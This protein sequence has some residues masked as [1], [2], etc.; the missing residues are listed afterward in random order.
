M[1]I[2]IAA[3]GTGGHVFPSLCVAEKLREL[4][5]HKVFFLGT[6]RGLEAG[7]V[8]S[9]GFPVLYVSAR[10]WN[11]RIGLQMFRMLGENFLGFCAM[12]WYFLWYRPQAFF[13]MGSYLS[14]LGGLWAK[15]LRVP[16][17]LHEQNVYPGLAN[18]VVARWARKVFLS[19]EET[20]EYLRTRGRVEVTG[21]PLR[22]EVVAWEGKKEEACALL[23]L[24]K[25]RKT[26]LVAGGSRGSSFLNRVFLEALDFLPK[27]MIQVVH[28]TGVEDFAPIAEYAE[29]QPFPYRVF[30]FLDAMGMAYAAA[31]V[32][33]C[34]AGANTVTELFFFGIPSILVPYR[35]ATENHQWYNAQWLVKQGLAVVFSEEELRGPLLARELLRLLNRPSGFPESESRR[36]QFR[37]SAACIAREI[38]DL[39]GEEG[40]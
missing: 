22:E 14:L 36:V 35:E 9:R 37:K 31:D 20:K 6:R 30:P 18:R 27:E 29:K 3:G 26:L 10:G 38:L 8:A 19:F 4:G 39:P 11:R 15:I 21:N 28:I 5:D 1:R 12:G 17:Y 34:R 16:I 25:S 32:A 13:A 7:V 33:F 24:S 23:G 40:C 2:F